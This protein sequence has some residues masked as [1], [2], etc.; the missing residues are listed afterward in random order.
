[1]TKK[2]KFPLSIECSCGESYTVRLTEKQAESR[3]WEEECREC[4][5]PHHFVPSYEGKGK[6]KALKEFVAVY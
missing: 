5:Q 1:M 6:E 4:N 3:M 2:P